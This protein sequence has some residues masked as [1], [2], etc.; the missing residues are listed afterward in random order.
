MLVAALLAGCGGGDAVDP[1]P[2][3]SVS[4][5]A[6]VADG[7]VEPTPAPSPVAGRI[8]LLDPGHNGGN[9]TNTSAI[10]KKVPDGRG[11]T[12][13]CNTTGTTTDEDD[14]YLA[15]P[16]HAFN[17]VVAESVKGLL[18]SKGVVVKMTR[19]DDKGI[20]PCV[21]KRAE[22][23]AEVN[24]DA[25]ISI[26]ADGAAAS[27]HGFHIAYS[28]PPLNAAQGP[29][30]VSLATALRDSMSA[31][32]LIISTYIGK[33][34][35]SAR[36]DL[37]G[38]NLSKRPAALVECGN[39]KNHDDKVAMSNPQGRAR[40]AEGIAAGILDWLTHNSAQS[41]RAVSS[42]KTKSTTSESASSSTKSTATTK[43]TTTAKS[44][45]SST[46]S[47]TKSTPKSTSSSSTSTTKSSTAN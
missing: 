35:L 26:H 27:G 30:S 10:N 40:F 34:G 3:A 19:E 22:M 28:K 18:E 4:D 47:T 2:A 39:M 15:L 9:A 37:A 25:M 42:G 5:G 17:F 6:S 20:G 41:L 12:K 7:S 11:G 31:E 36:D 24:A 44:K 16:E 33:Q 1:A 23:A 32:G 8:V 13:A 14:E 45:S 46:T 38:L 29:P 43:S 21:D